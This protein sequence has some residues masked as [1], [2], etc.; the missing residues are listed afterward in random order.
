[1]IIRAVARM[2]IL[3]ARLIN[4]IS[5]IAF[6]SLC[7]SNTGTIKRDDCAFLSVYSNI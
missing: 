1:M 2:H 6:A 7:F 4:F 5:L 3:S